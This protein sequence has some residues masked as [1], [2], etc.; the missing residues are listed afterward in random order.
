MK[1]PVKSHYLSSQDSMDEDEWSCAPW[2]I[3]FMIIL[4]TIGR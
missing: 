2:V 4:F 3:A 1:S